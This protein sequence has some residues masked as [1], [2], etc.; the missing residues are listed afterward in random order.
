MRTPNRQKGFVVL[1]ASLIGGV[2][3]AIGLAILTITIKQLGLS[4]AGRESHRSFYVADTAMECALYLNHLDRVT[5]NASCSEGVGVF[6]DPISGG[7][8][9]TKTT[10]FVCAGEDLLFE[11]VVLDGSL[12]ISSFSLGAE[13]STDE[14]CA[15]V[16][17]TKDSST[18]LTSFVSS[19]RNTCRDTQNKFERSIQIDF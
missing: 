5:V 17:V 3:L 4:S 19:G 18:G 16:T 8:V 13:N 14:I 9:C 12:Y 10:P 15:D 6:A 1:Y 7:S 2:V 11:P